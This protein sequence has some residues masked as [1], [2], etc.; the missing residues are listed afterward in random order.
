MSERPGNEA[1]LPRR[2]W[3]GFP[4]LALMASTA[5]QAQMGGAGMGGGPGGQRPAG[6]PPKSGEAAGCAA[7]PGAGAVPS[8]AMVQGM[9]HERLNRL[10]AELQLDSQS[11]PA[12]DRYAIAVTQLLDDELRRSLKPPLQAMPATLAME[13][14]ITDA[15]SRLAAWEEIQQAAKLL[16]ATLSQAQQDIANKRLVVSIDPKNWMGKV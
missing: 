9:A 1:V 11:R 2:A 14:Q 3:L 4:V 16:M 7:A 15:N 6:G 10:P 12:Y 5:V 13:Q 8:L